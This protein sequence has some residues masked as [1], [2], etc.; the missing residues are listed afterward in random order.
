[1]LR[2]FFSVIRWVN[3]LYLLLTFCGF[4]FLLINPLFQLAGYT[5]SLSNAAFVL[6]AL[7]V[8]LVAAG[9]YIIND[10]FDVEA[11][12]VNKPHK[13]VIGN[14]ISPDTAM[15]WYY[16]CNTAGI[17]SGFWLA[18]QAGNVKLGF[19]HIFSAAMLWFY[20]TYFK[21]K[22][23]TG[24]LL[25]SFMVA[26]SIFC[27][28]LFD[29]E[30]RAFTAIKMKEILKSGFE[31]LT[32]YIVAAPE[33]T[34]YTNKE[35]FETIFTFVTTYAGFAFLLNLIR[36]LVKDLEDAPGDEEA[37]Y[38]TLPLVA[39]FAFTKLLAGATV[40]LTIK[41]ITNF[42]IEQALTGQLWVA[43]ATL[44]LIQLP[45]MYVVYKLWVTNQKA[46]FTQISRVVK[47]V[48]LLGLA[49]L[50]Y[51]RATIV[52]TPQQMVLPPGI[53][54]ISVDIDSTQTQKP[55]TTATK[56]A[57]PDTAVIV[58]DPNAPQT[59]PATTIESETDLPKSMQPKPAG[60]VPAIDDDLLK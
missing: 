24:N 38:Q 57:N 8:M 50:P 27:I 25:V 9:G 53:E 39:G 17:A 7:S 31:T 47:V 32:G 6:L 29:T 55:D 2:S 10:Y 45:L 15:R 48:M 37:G 18:W 46:G 13:V 41:L 11:D 44:M 42:Q 5:P 22:P 49:Y 35:L 19:I 1:M 26:L 12:M 4:R 59:T 54:S 58:I 20:A 51:L 34:G 21:R 30:M 56:S 33:L 40:L 16:L 60:N 52:Y 28:L 3:L 43:V 14:Q 23:L 36:E